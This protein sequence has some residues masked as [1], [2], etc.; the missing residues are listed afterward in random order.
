MTPSQLVQTSLWKHQLE[1]VE[2]LRNQ[3]RVL[4]ANEMGTK[5]EKR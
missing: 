2:R 3:P 1:D 4:I 5:Q